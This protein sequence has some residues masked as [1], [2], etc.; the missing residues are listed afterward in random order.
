MSHNSGVE[1]E[2]YLRL[3]I[4]CTWLRKYKLERTLGGKSFEDKKIKGR[5]SSCMFRCGFCTACTI[6]S[7]LRRACFSFQAPEGALFSEPR[8]FR[9]CVPPGLHRFRNNLWELESLPVVKQALGYPP[10][11]RD[12]NPE[13]TAARNIE[14]ELGLQVLLETNPG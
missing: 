7:F 10:P 13:M 14:V 8:L 5:L 6:S 12:D 2:A 1:F 11:V 4:L 3:F 9:A